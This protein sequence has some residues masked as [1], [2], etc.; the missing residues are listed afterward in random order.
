MPLYHQLG[1][2]PPKRHTVFR[3][4]NGELFSEELVSTHGFSSVYS[5]VYHCYPPTIVKEIREPY[6]VNPK[7][8]R[9]KHLKHTSLRG[10]QVKPKAEI[11]R[12]SCRE[13][14]CIM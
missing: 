13:S 12:A 2:I 9:E 5:L 7:I 11:G 8:A 6:D 4:D 10:F 1:K 3:K 14:V